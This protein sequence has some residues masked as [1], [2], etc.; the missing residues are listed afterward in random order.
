MT[1]P[2]SATAQQPVILFATSA[3]LHCEV[4]LAAAAREATHHGTLVDA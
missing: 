3:L 4:F 2:V 1:L